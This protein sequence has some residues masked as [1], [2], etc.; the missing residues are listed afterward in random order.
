[1]LPSHDIG[2]LNIHAISFDEALSRVKIL[3]QSSK[4][5]YVVTP[6]IDHL[7]RLSK[8]KRMIPFYKSAALCLCDSRILDKMMRLKNMQIPEVITGS[9]LTQRLFDEVLTKTDSI[10]VI[11]GDDSVITKLRER[12]QHLTISNYNPPMGFIHSPLAVNETINYVVDKQAHYTFIAVGSPQQEL[13]AQKLAEQSKA[14]GVYLCIGA[15]ILFL[16]GAEVRAPIWIQKL[17]L[18]WCFRIMQNPIRF[19]KRYWEN[20]LSLRKIYQ[21]MKPPKSEQA[22]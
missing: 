10:L 16:T 9:T 12:Y 13:L 15:S 3:S 17:H 14:S 1:M 5:H 6:N 4:L 21:E 19:S 7:S 20:A 18:E 11:G 22:L 2:L 8:D